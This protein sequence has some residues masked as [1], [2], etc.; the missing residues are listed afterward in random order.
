MIRK[1]EDQITAG[2]NLS[3]QFF[4][5]IHELLQ[6]IVEYKKKQFTGALIINTP[7]QKQWCLYFGMGQ[8]L[9]ASGSEH[10][11]RRWRRQL[12]RAFQQNSFDNYYSEEY[13]R[14]KDSYECWDFHLLLALHKRKIISAEQVRAVMS[15][16]IAEVI[17][18]LNRQGVALCN[19]EKAY[20]NEPNNC[21]KQVFTREWKAGLRPSQ[22]MV[23]PP[24][25]G[26]ETIATL[27][28]GV[29]SWKQW[30]NAGLLNISPDQA[31]RLLRL[32]ELEE[33]T[34]PGVY[35]NLVKL[36]TGEQTLRDLSVLMKKE[37]IKIARSL[38]PYI[39]EDIISLETVSDLAT[40]E[41]TAETI[42]QKQNLNRRAED[43]EKTG[44]KDYS[45][46]S[47]QRPL[48][49]FVDDSEQSL[50]IMENI[51]TKGGYEF[52]GINNPTE[53][54]PCLLEKKPQLL[55]LDLIMPNT[56][57]YEL[58]SQLRKI[59]SF[60]NLPIVIVTGND[61]I[62]DRMRAK[63]VG[64]SD[65]ISKPIDRSQVLTL[66]LQYIQGK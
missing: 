46:P 8:L 30:Q 55:F 20:P 35:K 52:L 24:S 31:P 34:S 61:G 23:I 60:K 26:T 59:S 14:G 4:L 66:A 40:P 9:W 47:N 15:G 3:D 36:V 33:K 57:G 48:I 19:S 65:F 56:S 17:F 29:D 49:A 62:V 16:V 42:T 44:S 41:A 54:I 6:E 12:A 7:Q 18:D 11:R 5:L 28:A 22:Q 51:I 50:Q 37:P 38:Q 43:D 10:P 27:R 39:R 2:S 1:E 53:A 63:V 58:C 32:K 64:A 25:W 45:T 21:G 13:L